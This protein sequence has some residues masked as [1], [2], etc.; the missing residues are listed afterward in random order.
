[1]NHYHLI[2]PMKHRPPGSRFSVFHLF[3]H[4]LNN[5]LTSIGKNNIL[6][7]PVVIIGYD[8]IFTQIGIGQIGISAA[9]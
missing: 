4:I 2:C 9:L 5:I 3:K 7:Y 6:S 8:V 1:M